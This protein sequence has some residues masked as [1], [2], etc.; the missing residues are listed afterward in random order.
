[1]A[2]E[3]RKID[4]VSLRSATVEKVFNGEWVVVWIEHRRLDWRI[5]RLLINLMFLM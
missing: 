4:D 1:M 3:F 5:E 2:F